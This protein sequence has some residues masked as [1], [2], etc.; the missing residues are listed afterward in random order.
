MHSKQLNEW[1]EKKMDG[2][3]TGRRNK[4]QINL[5]GKSTFTLEFNG[6]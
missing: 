5:L 2:F 3:L 4:R 1:G 6:Q